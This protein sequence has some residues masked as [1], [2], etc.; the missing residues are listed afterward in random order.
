MRVAQNGEDDRA[1]FHGYVQL[2]KYTLKHTYVSLSP[3]RE[4]LGEFD[5]ITKV[6]GP[7][8]AIVCNL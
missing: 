4:K 1:G 7:D 5:I 6:T 3:L 8:C 2:Y